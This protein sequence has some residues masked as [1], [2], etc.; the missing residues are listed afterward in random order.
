MNASHARSTES[1]RERISALTACV[2][3]LVREGQHRGAFSA[4]EVLIA[5]QKTCLWHQAYG[6]WNWK[7][8]RHPTTKDSLWDLASLT[9]PLLTAAC[10]MRLCAAGMLTLDA[11]LTEEFPALRSKRAQRITLRHLLAHR[12]GLP[13]TAVLF[14]PK[15]SNPQ[16]NPQ[17]PSPA[18]ET[19]L[20]RLLALLEAEPTSGQSNANQKEIA[21][22]Q[23]AERKMVYSDLGY[24]LLG[25]WL[26][27]RTGQ[28][29]RQLFTT[30][31]TV[32]LGITD[33]Q[34]CCAPPQGTLPQGAPAQGAQ[35]I[36]SGWS[37]LRQRRLRGEVHD[38][39][40]HGWGGL[41]GHAG[42]FGTARGIWRLLRAL[43]GDD[44]QWLAPDVCTQMQTNQN[45]PPLLPRGLGWDLKPTAST[46]AS[47]GT[48]MPP[49]S[50][51]HTAFTG[52]SLWIDPERQLQVIFLCNR[53]ALAPDP[54]QK[55]N[56]KQIIAWRPHFHDALIHHLDRHLTSN[57]G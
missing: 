10:V 30:Q 15:G 12:A 23:I 52:P 40:A 39:N 47:C 29:L 13:P 5:R 25:E 36:P 6:H 9:K 26:Q 57:E 28:A 20:H 42:L 8:Q 7:T 31:V 56:Q 18:R 46:Y 44:P 4:A 14:P 27:R 35:V 45:P 43:Q 38:D 17:T 48:R 19:A 49:G 3:A 37:V 22:R 11:P 21:E 1:E 32:P 53:T 50:F 24:I 54:A 33:A 34:L 16:E 51:G 41:A 55:A 2:D